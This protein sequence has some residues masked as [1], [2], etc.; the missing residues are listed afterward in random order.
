MHVLCKSKAQKFLKVI[1]LVWKQSNFVLRFI[2]SFFFSVVLVQ[3]AEVLVAREE[4]GCYWQQSTLTD[5]LPE[6]GEELL[7]GL[8]H[9]V[10][11]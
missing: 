5:I 8:R 4:I 10:P 11:A 3:L 6:V 2:K 9:L 1:S 7:D